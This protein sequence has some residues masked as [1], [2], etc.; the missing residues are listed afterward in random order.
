MEYSSVNTGRSFEHELESMSDDEFKCWIMA[1][2]IAYLV[3]ARLT[4]MEEERMRLLPLV[5][6][7]MHLL[8]PAD[9]DLVA[10]IKLRIVKVGLNVRSG[11]PLPLFDADRWELLRVA[12]W[13][14]YYTRQWDMLTLLAGNILPVVDYLEKQQNEPIPKGPSSKHEW[15]GCVKVGCADVAYLHI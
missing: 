2:T 3:N 1:G 14:M 5:I 6:S 13:N 10:K 7:R 9:T 4:P 15:T 12:A 8:S 11:L